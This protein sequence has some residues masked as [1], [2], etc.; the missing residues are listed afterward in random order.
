MTSWLQPQRI[1]QSACCLSLTGAQRGV[2]TKDSIEECSR[3]Y[4]A[5]KPTQCARQDPYFEAVIDRRDRTRKI[6]KEQSEE[7]YL[8]LLKPHHACLI[9]VAKSRVAL[10]TFFFDDKR[11]AGGFW[12]IPQDSVEDSVNRPL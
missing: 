8:H 10:V 12:E 9:T 4:W 7:R 11:F 1:R 3:E 6:V 2:P 5:S